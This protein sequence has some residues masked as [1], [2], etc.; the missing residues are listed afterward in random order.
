M[1]PADRLLLRDDIA[2]LLRS[3]S[4]WGGHAYDL[5]D[6]VLDLITRQYRVE[7]LPRRVSRETFTSRNAQ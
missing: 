1:T 4:T 2:T 7:R 3:R 5:A 6:A